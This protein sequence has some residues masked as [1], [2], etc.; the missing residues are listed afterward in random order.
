MQNSHGASGSV[1]PPIQLYSMKQPTPDRCGH[2]RSCFF[3]SALLFVY[4]A[5]HFEVDPARSWLEKAEV[6]WRCALD[7]DPDFWTP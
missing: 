7:L 3:P 5:R 1:R 6:R 4:T 2:S